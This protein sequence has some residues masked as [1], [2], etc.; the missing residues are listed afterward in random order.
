MANKSRSKQ[1]GIEDAER[2]KPV[3]MF[4]GVLST[5]ENG[6]GEVEFL[7]P[8]YMGAVKVMVVGADF[9]KYGSAEK[10]I[11]VKAPVVLNSSIPRSLKVGDELTI[12]VEI[13]A[14]EEGIGDIKVSLEFNSEI[15]KE[16]IELKNKEKKT[17]FFKIKVPNR[18]GVEK[19]KISVNSSRYDHEEVTNIAI[20]SNSPYIYINEVKSVDREQNFNAPKEFVSGSVNG[21]ITISSSPI[22]AIDERL[23]WLIRYPYGCVEQTT[24]SVFPQLFIS[25]L[26][27]EKN[28]D[29]KEITKNINSGIARFSRFQLYDGSFS[30]WIGG[31]R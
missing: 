18:I 4:K 16:E 12:Q 13:F 26:S 31:F 2:F 19:I 23:Q 20:N 11:L 3:V 9:E 1:L 15:Q 6:E 30:Y 25:K 27:Y 28:F 14:L 29:M 24:S 7:M 8:N 22:L 10:E 21:R 5:D 17:L